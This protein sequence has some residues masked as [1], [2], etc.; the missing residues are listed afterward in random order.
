MSQEPQR[1]AQLQHTN[2]VPIYSVHR[3]QRLQAMCM[4]FLGPNTLEHLLKCLELSR[5][6]PLSGM[7]IVST[8]ASRSMSTVLNEAIEEEPRATASPTDEPMT[9]QR[10]SHVMQRLG[11]MSYLNAVVWIMSRVADGLA[12]AHEHGIVHRDLKPANILLADDGEP[13]I[14]D[15]NL[16][17]DRSAID[18]TAALMGGTLPYI[19]PE[20][21]RALRDGGTVGLE[22]DVYSLGVI[23]Y[24]MLSGRVPYR[25]YH[26]A[27]HE[28]IGQMLDDRLQPPEPIRTLN[29]AVTPALA[30]IVERCLATEPSQRYRSARDLQEDLQRHLENRPLR[31]APTAA[32]GSVAE[33]GCAGIRVWR[34]A[35]P[36]PYAAW[37]L[38][39]VWERPPGPVVANWLGPMREMLA[40]FEADLN[41][42][43]THLNSPYVSD[44]ELATSVQAAGEALVQAGLLATPGASTMTPDRWLSS[45]QRHRLRRDAAEMLY[46]LATG[47]AH[48]AVRDPTS[49]EKQRLL[50]EAMQLNS[51]ISLVRGDGR[52]SQAVMLQALVYSMPP[53]VRPTLNVRGNSR[54]SMCEVQVICVR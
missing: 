19:G 3:T 48:Q 30:A 31:H 27:F 35:Q 29:S 45:Q 10:S 44:Q 24:Q 5:S 4:P 2:I 46:L 18:A 16:A 1:L 50:Y 17:T 37:F 7:A 47:K 38:C 54:K 23:L 39:P 40:D 20:Q 14:L 21:M 33:S 34:R 22:S 15:F 36:W 42:A 26:G 13:L 11:S 41:A 51:Q 52:T 12:C 53:I 8:I 43:R 32:C 28:I 25:L 6:L 9:I 49:G